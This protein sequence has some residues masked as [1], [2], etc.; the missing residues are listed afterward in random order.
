MAAQYLARVVERQSTYIDAFLREELTHLAN[1]LL[2][3]VVDQV[4]E[5]VTERLERSARPARLERPERSERSERSTA[6]PVLASPS[7]LKARTFRATFCF[8]AEG[9]PQASKA[10]CVPQLYRNPVTLAQ[11]WQQ[12]LRSGEHGSQAEFA[13]KLSISRA[14]VTQVLHL[15]KLTPDVL[16]I[17]AALG[18]PLPSRII[19]E[20][21]LRSMVH[22]P[23]AEQRQELGKI[24][25]KGRQMAETPI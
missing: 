10:R 7:K 18:D 8:P 3:G 17:I 14:R 25:T 24:L 21:T 4:V 6:L 19:A 9:K 1:R 16:N 2:E 13:R 22:R 23:A 5:R 11:E 15:L 20:R 12:A